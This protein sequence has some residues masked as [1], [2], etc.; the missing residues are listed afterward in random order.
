MYYLFT[1]KCASFLFFAV[2]YSRGTGNSDKWLLIQNNF[3]MM[4]EDS[5]PENTQALEHSEDI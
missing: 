2:L 4:R 3:T 1:N 5:P